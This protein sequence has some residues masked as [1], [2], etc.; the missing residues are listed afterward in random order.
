MSV[1]RASK[2]RTQP[3]LEG[4]EVSL[5][6]PHSVFSD[7]SAKLSPHATR[8]LLHQVESVE[9]AINPDRKEIKRRRPHEKTFRKV[10]NG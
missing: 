1:L 4:E 6:N 7:V 5:Q 3:G 9:Q 8:A 10:D 2:P